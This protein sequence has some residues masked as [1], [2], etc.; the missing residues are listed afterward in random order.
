MQFESFKLGGSPPGG[1]QLNGIEPAVHHTHT[2]SHSRNNSISSSSLGSGLS[3]FSFSSSSTSLK[4]SMTNND[5]TPHSNAQAQNKRPNSHHRRR[6][7]V[8][9][10]RESAELMGVSIPDLPQSSSDD[11]VN[12]GDKDSIRRR[13]LWALEG[14]GEV[15]FSKVELPQLD[16]VIK[17]VENNSDFRMYLSISALIS[18]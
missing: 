7:S 16:D 8:S 6:S 9:T 10:R 2:R 11:N 18:D 17:P 5:A 4:S 12:F 13:A 1:A 3:G 14:K 15:A